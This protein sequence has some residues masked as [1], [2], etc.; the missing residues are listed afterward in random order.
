MSLFVKRI[1]LPVLLVAALLAV[2]ACSNDESE[3]AAE[4]LPQPT[5]AVQP[6]A[7]LPVMP[8]NPNFLV[9]ATD[10]PLPPFSDFDAFGNVTGFNAAVME[11]IAAQSGLDY[12][13]VV[14]PNQGVLDSIAAGSAR[15]FDAVMSALV[16]PSTP[17]PG[18]A[19]TRPYLE[20]GQVVMTLVDKPEISS[21]AD[22]RPGIAVG[23]LAE[24]DGLEAARQLGIVETDLRAD[25]VQPSQLVQALIDE[26]VDAVIVD[27]TMGDYF[28]GSFPEQLKLAGDAADPATWLAR[29]TYG[30]AIA[31][32][33]A[34]LLGKLDGALDALDE[35]GELD[36]MMVQWLIPEQNAAAAVNPGESRVGTPEGEIVV[37]VVGSFTDMDPA[38]LTIDFISWEVK[39]NIMSGLYRFSLEGEL[40]P[41]LA[42]ALP[43]VSEDKLEYTIPLR[44]GL[45]FPDGTSFTAEDVKWSLD[46]AAG[47]GNYLVNNVLKDSDDNNFA[48]G[49]AVQI[50]DPATVKIVL[51]EPTG[52]FPAM[53]ATP[54]FFPISPECWGD[55]G[56][57]GSSCGGLG[58]YTIT[59]WEPNSRLRMQAN[60]NW[61]GQPSPAFDNLTVRFYQDAGSVKRSL[62]EFESVDV[63][64]TGLSRADYGELAAVDLTGDGQPD[65]K[66]W[67]GPST[68]KSYVIFEQG[69]PPW[70]SKLVR[71]AAALSLDREALARDIFG[72]D[73][74]PLLSPVPNDIP[75]HID[76]LPARD[77]SRARLLLEQ[78]GYT[79]STKLPIEIFFVND[80]RYSAVEDAYANAIKAQLEETGVFE[81]TVTGAPWN[82]FRGQI[83]ECGYPAYILGW[84]SPGQPVTVLDATAWT[85]FFVENTSEVFCSNYE[86]ARMTEL[87]QEAREEP[88]TAAR[89]AIYGQIQ[90]LWASELPTLDLTQEPRKA[91][92]RPAVDGVRIDALG[93]MRYE[94]LTKQGE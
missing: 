74:L 56:N 73:R 80:G 69:N 46:R 6:T 54:P 22:L 9:V 72:G 18:I 29:K 65:L 1:A 38:S 33:N 27:S 87:V 79:A 66:P 47:L 91:V 41:L 82:T 43:S 75:G 16:I 94:Y 5:I 59:G 71:E 83:A 44:T 92:T 15:D 49:D 51:Q 70:D 89:L 14:T 2:S 50:V 8:G 86:S 52:S 32:D 93:L 30:I 7:D 24:S 37:G 42:A 17:P 68:F 57:P 3:P 55:A 53:L 39:S 31:A 81:V 36:Q 88:D 67:V 76:A 12:E 40:E 58:P 34:E 35:S 20:V 90:D 48:D 45:L 78:A 21:P 26:S 4:G 25:F 10:A 11:R 13:F 77:L 85:D 63:A 28:V 64:W 19:F 62:T 61:P 23:V 84:P 60:P